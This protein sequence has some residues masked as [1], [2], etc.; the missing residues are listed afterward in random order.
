MSGCAVIILVAIIAACVVAIKSDGPKPGD[1]AATAPPAAVPVSP[2]KLPPSSP[3]T[4]AMIFA[5]KYIQTDG[6]FQMLS[7][8][9]FRKVPPYTFYLGKG[10]VN[11]GGASLPFE[12][13]FYF[14]PENGSWVPVS[15][16]F[17]GRNVFDLDA[18]NKAHREAPGEE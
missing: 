3:S 8:D 10:I 1:A 16:D 14:M 12:V 9:V 13:V 15:V 18:S 11:G 17:A 7:V 4:V 6:K 2:K 5:K